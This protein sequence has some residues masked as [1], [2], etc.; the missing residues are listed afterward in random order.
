LSIFPWAR[1]RQRKGAIKLHYL[2]DQSGS[3]PA[4]MTMTDGKRHE[5]RV[6]KEDE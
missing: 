6:A 2:F 1:Y 4:F 5:L 3:L